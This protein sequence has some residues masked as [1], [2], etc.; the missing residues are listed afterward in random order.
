MQK[1]FK[2]KFYDLFRDSAD[3]KLTEGV[4]EGDTLIHG[5]FASET[6]NT[7]SRARKSQ[8][9]PNLRRAPSPIQAYFRIGLYVEGGLFSEWTG[10]PRCVTFSRF[11]SVS[12][13]WQ[14]DHEFG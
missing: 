13:A 3:I 5:Y 4:D 11:V 12:A 8:K 9:G 10:A 1:P 14:L 2:K 7:H 6:H